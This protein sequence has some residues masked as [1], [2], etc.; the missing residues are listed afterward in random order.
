MSS[1]KAT[2]AVTLLAIFN[3][4]TA[5]PTASCT[6]GSALDLSKWKLQLPIGSPGSPT[7][8]TS[9]QLCSGYQDPAK[10]YFFTESG[11]ALVMKVPGSPS[12]TGCVTTKNSKHCRTE[13]RESNPN[14]WDPKAATNKL[15]ATLTVVTADDSKYGTVVGQIH[16]DDS[17]SSKPVCELYYSKSGKLT[18]GVEKTRAGGSSVYTEVGNVPVGTKF[19]YAITYQGGK[20]GVSINGGAVK[21]LSQNELDNPNSYFK[22]GNY[23]QGNSPSVVKF[24][25][26]KTQH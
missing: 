8:I 7:T 25:E 17:I 23:N 2:Y 15:S 22:A 16:I 21:G 1:R 6:S 26:I 9:S 4:T 19:S 3:L 18:M 14:S 5:A 20:L 13:L 24:F 12:D 10:A 11:G